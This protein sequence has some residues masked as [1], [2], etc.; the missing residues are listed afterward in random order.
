MLL[1]ATKNTQRELVDHH[2]LCLLWE[3]QKGQSFILKNKAKLKQVYYA[4]QKYIYFY[5]FFIIEKF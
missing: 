5:L 2:V 4:E 1:L 3:S